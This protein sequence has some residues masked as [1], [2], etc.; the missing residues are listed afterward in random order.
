MFFRKSAPSLPS[1]IVFKEQTIVLRPLKRSKNLRLMYNAKQKQFNLTLPLYTTKSDVQGFLERAEPWFEKKLKSQVKNIIPHH[2]GVI[3]IIGIPY[4]IHFQKDIKR[5]VTFG[6]NFVSVLDPKEQ[7]L[8]LLEKAI[9][10]KI[11]EFLT[12]T[13]ETYAKCLNVKVS[14]VSIR[15]THSRWG[16]CSSSGNLSYS[17]RL[18]FAPEEVIKYVCAH[19]VSHLIHMNHSQAFWDTVQSL[20]PTYKKHKTWLSQQG[21]QLFLYTF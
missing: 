11:L 15:D 13:S 21:R 4:K 7:F 19:E 9:Q 3:N 8:P 16:S 2:E 20:C 18:A 10:S 5:K 17:W 6:P 14:K 12:Q 1:S